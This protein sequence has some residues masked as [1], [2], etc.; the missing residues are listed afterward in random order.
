L[1]SDM[2]KKS[3]K[4]LFKKDREEE[5]EGPRDEAALDAAGAGAE[6]PEDAPTKL[7]VPVLGDPTG[8]KDGPNARY[9]Q[10]EE[11]TGATGGEDLIGHGRVLRGDIRLSR[12]PDDLAMLREAGKGTTS[13]EK[14]E[15]QEAP[16]AAS[17]AKKAVAL[18]SPQSWTGGGGWK[19][20]YKPGLDGG[21]GSIQVTDPGGKSRG[22]VDPKSPHF[23]GIITE[24][25]KYDNHGFGTKID[26]AFANGGNE[27]EP[28][29]T[30]EGEPA[31]FGGGESGASGAGASWGD[32][33]EAA[34]V[35]ADT[36]DTGTSA[37]EP[38][39]APA[40]EAPAPEAPDR[41]T[42]PV[43]A[44]SEQDEDLSRTLSGAPEA[45]E[46]AAAPTPE[47]PS[48]W[49]QL[50]AKQG[51][52]KPGHTAMFDSA[53]ATP[54][55]AAAKIVAQQGPDLGTSSVEP[56]LGTSPVPEPAPPVSPEEESLA[57]FDAEF[58]TSELPPDTAEQETLAT[59]ELPTPPATP[60]SV[61]AKI[62]AQEQVPEP[63]P[64]PEQDQKAAMAEEYKR[65]VAGG[66]SSEE[67]VRQIR[68]GMQLN[69]TTT[70]PQAAP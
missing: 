26:P 11:G 58:G 8:R 15:A 59:P 32:T 65:L 68:A 34:S 7:T 17:A 12:D 66:M 64:A 36:P 23:S 62:Y 39:E 60:E 67:A 13:P 2:K 4:R 10:L 47:D 37:G 48:Y 42:S 31:D 38:I 3:V 54:E 16:T 33:P 44:T 56:D 29:S 27:G 20:D 63:A 19:Y 22:S 25:F 45:P 28:T 49:D 55:S 52:P 9:S 5:D 41:G 18:S 61:G 46:P 57:A 1:A 51:R 14:P 35:P 21:I 69:V 24:F 50:M 43:P 30:K 53:P 70:L 40:P 6:V